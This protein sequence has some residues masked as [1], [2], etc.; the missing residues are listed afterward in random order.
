MTGFTDE[1]TRSALLAGRLVLQWSRDYTDLSA[2]V[3]A[4]I[5]NTSTMPQAHK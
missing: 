2:G 5:I 1:A 4:L 3:I